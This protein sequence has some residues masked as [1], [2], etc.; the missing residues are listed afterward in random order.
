VRVVEIVRRTDRDVVD[1]SRF[2][3]AARL[4]EKAVEALDLAEELHVERITVEHADGVIRIGRG[5]EATA[6]VADGV[7]MTR[8]HETAGADQG[9]VVHGGSV[10]S[11]NKKGAV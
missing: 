8:R 11:E 5:Q 2:G 6:G 10:A 9:K 4:L 3:T 1:A 7:E